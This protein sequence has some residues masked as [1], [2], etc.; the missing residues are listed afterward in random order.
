MKRLRYRYKLYRRFLV[1]IW[2]VVGGSLFRLSKVNGLIY[3]ANMIRL[4]FR[5]SSKMRQFLWLSRSSCS[6]KLKYRRF[7][8]LYLLRLFYFGV[9]RKYFNKL[10]VLAS[11]REGFLVEN[12]IIL[13]EFRLS[14]VLYRSFFFLDI[15]GMKRIL[16]SLNIFVN[17][18]RILWINYQL[19]VGDMIHLDPSDW[20]S[21]RYGVFLRL[22]RNR[23]YC[24][25]PRYLFV[26]FIFMF[27]L[28]V[29]FP[30][31]LDVS[32]PVGLDIYRCMDLV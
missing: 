9:R 7:L 4:G 11:K 2:G 1:D 14:S 15:V 31:Y 20:I 12:F 24:S 26:S 3:S 19:R 32:Y 30:K 22:Q 23:V 18:K 5:V 10:L 27:I 28:L 29:K 25:V 13:L 8:S 21:V 6:F 16:R 17:K